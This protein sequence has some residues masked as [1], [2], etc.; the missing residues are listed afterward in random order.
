MRWAL[1]LVLAGVVALAG[2]GPPTL[3]KRP[4]YWADQSV[5][6]TAY[7]HR[8]RFLVLHYTSDHADTRLARTDRPAR[9]RALPCRTGPR[10]A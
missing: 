7:N 10:D 6:A 8:V 9:E 2:C 1:G 3:E 5:R 4:G